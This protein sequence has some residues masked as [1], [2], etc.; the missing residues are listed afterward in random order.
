MNANFSQKLHWTCTPNFYD[1]VWNIVFCRPFF[2][3]YIASCDLLSLIITQI[4]NPVIKRHSI[5]DLSKASNFAY[6]VH[7]LD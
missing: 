3:Y 6:T 5:P 1:T 2:K 4:N 7:A